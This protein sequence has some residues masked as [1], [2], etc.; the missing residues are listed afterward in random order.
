[1][2]RYSWSRELCLCRDKFPEVFYY[3]ILC[4]RGFF[5]VSSLL[6][7]LWACFHARFLCSIDF[8]SFSL[9]K[10]ATL[11]FPGVLAVLVL[12]VSILPSLL[13]ASCRPYCA[14]FAH[15]VEAAYCI[16]HPL[17]S[18]NIL[19]GFRQ[20]FKSSSSS[21]APLSSTCLRWVCFRVYISLCPFLPLLP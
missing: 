19:R 12:W 4:F 8:P 11:L 9:I 2:F 15:V 14:S 5:M 6:I 13:R 21:A 3:E 17:T 16:A 7:G 10:L 20:C 1:M 18:S